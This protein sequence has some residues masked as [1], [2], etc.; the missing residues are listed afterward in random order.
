MISMMYTREAY[1]LREHMARPE[2]RCANGTCGRIKWRA[3]A[4]REILMKIIIKLYFIK[5]SNLQCF[6]VLLEHYDYGNTQTRS[7]SFHRL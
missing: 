2:F 3:G 5:F 4:F 1:R 7:C 6:D